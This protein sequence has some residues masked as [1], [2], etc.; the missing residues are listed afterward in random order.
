MTP[1]LNLLA[2]S[3]QTIVTKK[4]FARGPGAPVVL[5]ALTARLLIWLYPHFHVSMRSGH[6]KNFSTPCS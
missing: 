3:P 1:N 6:R 2:S 5:T 4:N